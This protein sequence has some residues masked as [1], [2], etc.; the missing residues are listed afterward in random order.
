MPIFRGIVI[1][2]QREDLGKTS[3]E[4]FENNL[5]FNFTTKI[6]IKPNGKN[7]ASY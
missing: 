7:R 5:K 2:R 6:G 1:G 4:I 3:R